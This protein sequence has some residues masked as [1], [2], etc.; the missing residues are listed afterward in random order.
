MN[1]DGN[2]EKKKIGCS[3][4]HVLLEHFSKKH[5]IFMVSEVFLESHKMIRQRKKYILE[6]NHLRARSEWL[7]WPAVHLR[8]RSV[9]LSAT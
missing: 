2:Q 5:E 4:K 8:L 3:R 7:K 6:N 1:P 9:A